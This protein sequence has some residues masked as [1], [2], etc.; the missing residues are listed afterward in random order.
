MTMPPWNYASYWGPLYFP[1]ILQFSPLI[2]PF[3][4]QA[5]FMF[6]VRFSFLTFFFS[7]LSIFFFFS[8]N[9]FYFTRS[10]PLSFIFIL[11][12]FLHTHFLLRTLIVDTLNLNDLSELRYTL[13]KENQ[14]QNRSFVRETERWNCYNRRNG[15]IR[16][17]YLDQRD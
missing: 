1:L 16:I 4:F 5:P 14:G 8:F 15:L 12:L 6:Q 13:S 9:F 3:L 7:F 2:S 17:K 10:C 11:H